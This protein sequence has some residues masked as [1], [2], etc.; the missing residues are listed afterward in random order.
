MNFF[1]LPKT[2]NKERNEKNFE[3]KKKEKR[4]ETETRQRKKKR[5][6]QHVWRID[7]N[8]FF[9]FLLK[10]KKKKKKKMMMMMMMMKKKKNAP[11]KPLRWLRRRKATQSG[12]ISVSRSGRNRVKS[13]EIEWN[14]RRNAINERSQGGPS[15]RLLL[16]FFFVTRPEQHDRRSNPA[17]SFLFLI[18]QPGSSSRPNRNPKKTLITLIKSG[19]SLKNAVLLATRSRRNKRTPLDEK[20]RIDPTEIAFWLVAGSPIRSQSGS[21]SFA[22]QK[23][24]QT[25]EN[26]TR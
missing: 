2:R 15:F 5:A 3:E 10:K 22:T 23:K 20:K 21:P 25:K 11:L 17:D 18:F 8:S 19:K 26:K 4:K 12:P 16:F 7:P 1:F 24:N 14:S 13:S 6:A 9:Y